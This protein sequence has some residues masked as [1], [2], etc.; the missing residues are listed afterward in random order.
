MELAGPSVTGPWY[1]CRACRGAEDEMV[2]CPECEGQGGWPV[3]LYGN[4]ECGADG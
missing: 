2:D 3:D 4:A 1:V